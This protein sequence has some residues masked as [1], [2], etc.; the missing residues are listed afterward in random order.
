ML[1]RLGELVARRPNS[2]AERDGYIF[3]DSAGHL[4]AAPRTLRGRSL[5]VR[6]R[7]PSLALAGRAMRWGRPT[8]VRYRLNRKKKM[9]FVSKSSFIDGFT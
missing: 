7:V 5:A 1:G 3:T 4:R 8:Q 2:S 6:D 9:R